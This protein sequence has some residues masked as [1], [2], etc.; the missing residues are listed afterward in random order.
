MPPSASR[1]RIDF[2]M[3]P[4]TTNL[5]ATISTGSKEFQIKEKSKA[6]VKAGDAWAHPVIHVGKLYLRSQDTLMCYDVRATE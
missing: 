4:S 1:T 6:A 2:N 3:T 5:S